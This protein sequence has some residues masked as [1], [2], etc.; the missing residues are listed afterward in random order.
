MIDYPL[1]RLQ[2]AIDAGATLTVRTVDGHSLA[3]TLRSR[4]G[5][6]ISAY[7]PDLASVASSII[8]LWFV[9]NGID[10]PRDNGEGPLRP[11]MRAALAELGAAHGTAGHDGYQTPGCECDYCNAY[12]SAFRAAAEREAALM[13]ATQ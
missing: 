7:G 11:H 13:P 5:T 10:R 2:G 6:E 4:N 8:T 1:A 9:H 3:A 12:S